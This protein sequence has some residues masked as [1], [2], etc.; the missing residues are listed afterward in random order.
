LVAAASTRTEEVP[1]AAYAGEARVRISL[2]GY[3][4]VYENGCEEMLW[5]GKLEEGLRERATARGEERRR[6]KL[7]QDMYF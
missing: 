7:L 5:R 1:G 2:P 6:C 4:L 3:K